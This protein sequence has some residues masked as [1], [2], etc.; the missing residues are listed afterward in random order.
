MAVGSWPTSMTYARA[1][2]T[3]RHVFVSV[4]SFRSALALIQ[5]LVVM[6]IMMLMIGA[7]VDVGLRLGFSLGFGS[8]GASGSITLELHQRWC[9]CRFF[10]RLLRPHWWTV[11]SSFLDHGF[12]ILLRS[13]RIRGVIG[14]FSLVMGLVHSVLDFGMMIIA[15]TANTLSKIAFVLHLCCCRLVLYTCTC[16][17]FSRVC[18]SIVSVRYFN[19]SYDARFRW[20]YMS[21]LMEVLST[22][23]RGRQVWRRCS[24]SSLLPRQQ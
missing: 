24:T 6:I 5:V 8:L 21:H 12:G 18:P 15:C 2:L 9:L 13:N 23:V 17:W 1:S 4:V 19:P 22:F 10:V 14:P 7:D 16:A 11:R 3:V 20:F